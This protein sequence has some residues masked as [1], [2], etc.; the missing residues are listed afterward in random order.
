MNEG[1]TSPRGVVGAILLILFV[2]LPVGCS[3]GWISLPS[4][5]GSVPSTSGKGG[6]AEKWE[7]G[8]WNWPWDPKDQTDV[9][10]ARRGVEAVVPNGM[11]KCDR[12]SARSNRGCA[13]AKNFARKAVPPGRQL[14]CL[15]TLW[16]NESGWDPFVANSSS[17][18]YGITQAL[19]PGKMA[20]AGKDWR[21]NPITQVV[22]GLGYIKSRYGTPCA[23][24][25]FWN[26]TDPRPHPNH[27]Y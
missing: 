6:A 5:G 2:L 27:W 9:D 1:N 26:R 22:W 3:Q 24:L 17:G 7:M 16:Y 20:S 13:I 19:P 12:N 25:A 18:A 23:A 21:T 10:A 8:D 14:N 15:D 4:G 11:R